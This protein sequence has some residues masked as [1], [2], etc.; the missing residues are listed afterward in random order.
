MEVPNYNV[1][2]DGDSYMHEESEPIEDEDTVLRR[3]MQESMQGVSNS[4][5]AVPISGI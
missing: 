2:D 4:G 1:D 5:G 3:V